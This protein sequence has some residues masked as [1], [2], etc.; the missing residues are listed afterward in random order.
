MIDVSQDIIPPIAQQLRNKSP[1]T[2][3]IT[4]LPLEALL[5]TRL[6]TIKMRGQ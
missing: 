5:V 4:A 3:A 2:V 1:K 6:I